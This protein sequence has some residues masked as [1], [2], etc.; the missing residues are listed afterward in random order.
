MEIAEILFLVSSLI[1]IV[2]IWIQ[3]VKNF[4]AK[5][6]VISPIVSSTTLIGLLLTAS[7]NWILNFYFNLS[8]TLLTALAWLIIFIQYF[9]FKNNKTVISV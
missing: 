5:L 1:F 4:N 8:M 2:S 9:I 3:V 7:A 6:C